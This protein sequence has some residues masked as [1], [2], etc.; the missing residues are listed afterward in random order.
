MGKKKIKINSSS[1]KKLNR[2]LQRNHQNNKKHRRAIAGGV[3][4][5]RTHPNRADQPTT[6][7][8]MHQQATHHVGFSYEQ[9]DCHIS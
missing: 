6:T 9:P 7:R 4:S 2:I 5:K 8:D 1:K 3:I